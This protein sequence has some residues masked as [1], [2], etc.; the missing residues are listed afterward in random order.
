MSFGQQNDQKSNS[1]NHSNGTN[2]RKNDEEKATS[3]KRFLYL[4]VNNLSKKWNS[5]DKL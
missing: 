1:F 4:Y 5:M 3:G 2:K